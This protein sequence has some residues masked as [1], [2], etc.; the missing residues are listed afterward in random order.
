LG[1]RVVFYGREARE[2]DKNWFVSTG[3]ADDLLKF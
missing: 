2:V 1:E 3:F